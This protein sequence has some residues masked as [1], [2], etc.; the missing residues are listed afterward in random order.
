M[1]LKTQYSKY[2]TT[3]T[4]EDKGFSQSASPKGSARFEINEDQCSLELKVQNLSLCEPDYCYKCYLLYPEKSNFISTCIGQ[5]EIKNYKGALHT[6]LSSSD[7]NSSGISINDFDTIVV[8]Y[9]PLNVNSKDKISFPLVGYK[10]S[11]TSWKDKF[12]ASLLPE[13]QCKPTINQQEVYSTVVNSNQENDCLK[14]NNICLDKDNESCSLQVANEQPAFEQPN[15]PILDYNDTNLFEG[16]D[17]YNEV[18]DA[19]GNNPTYVPEHF[20]N[21]ES[22]IKILENMLSMSFPECKPFSLPENSIRW[23]KVQNH[24]LLKR[25]LFS[26]ECSNLILTN[27]YLNTSYY[28]YGYYIV[29]INNCEG[30]NN[31]IYGIPSLYGID[32][33]PANNYCTWKSEN[34]SGELYGEFGYWVIKFDMVNCT[35]IEA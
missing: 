6:V 27:N 22:K 13:I 24:E 25:V 30:S 31:F 17:Y 21:T 4:E 33:Q 35:I 3:L 11:K 14:Q 5:L 18:A 19:N 10:N 32:P 15:I 28:I 12:T 20:S 23:W 16:F 9:E 7:V 26:S 34:N 8:T 1:A 29:G 2:Y